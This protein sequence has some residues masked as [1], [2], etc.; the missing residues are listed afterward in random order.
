MCYL[1]KNA[2]L[3]SLSKE[4]IRKIVMS[5]GSDEPKSDNSGNLIFQ[6][7]C[8][9]DINP[10][11]SYKLYYYHEPNGEHKGKIFH[12]Y[13]GCNESFG[14]IELVIRAKRNQG[15]NFT[16]YKSLRYIAQI[17]GKLITSSAE[18]IEQRQQRIDDF[19]WINRLKNAKKKQ[20][21]V[22]TLS[23][24][25]ENILEIF[26][27]RPH[28]VWLNE[29]ITREALSRFEIGY[30]GEH[31]A[32]TI[33]H[34]D[35]DGRLIGLRLR[36]LDPIDVERI[37]KYVPANIEGK[38][39]SH[40]LGSTLY[41]LSQCG[42]K[43]RRCKKCMLVE[44]EKS[45]LQAYSYYNEDCFA[46]ATCGS[47]ISLTQ[48]K[49]LLHD[50]KIEELIYAPDRDYH[51]SDSFEAQIWW[52]KIMKRLAPLVPYVKV[53]LLADRKERLGFKDSPTD[54]GKEI[55]NQL[56]DEKIIITMNDIIEAKENQYN[57]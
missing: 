38:F 45:V 37:G 7:I 47:A 30:W 44:A 39:L 22:P 28:E 29:N 51:E 19:T 25:N 26:D 57:E 42:E 33:P 9:N 2:I 50:L 24:I 54:K 35:K 55:L 43:I 21:A 34:R 11:N 6:T 17:T 13:S 14:I 41:G 1:D 36:Y 8:H 10:N 4:D 48:I 31:D 5:L 23:E 46:L 20:K 56:L 3:D 18:D 32:I 16:W 40:Q 12:C 49:I 15:S 53:T 52:N 27:Y